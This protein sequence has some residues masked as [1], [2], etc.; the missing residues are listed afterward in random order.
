MLYVNHFGQHSNPLPESSGHFHDTNKT[1]FVLVF[2]SF[3]YMQYIH[4]YN[5]EALPVMAD[6]C[7]GRSARTGCTPP[8]EYDHPYVISS[9]NWMVW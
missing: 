2:V 6:R 4:P 3:R 8:Q 1:V 5:P 9:T 7:L